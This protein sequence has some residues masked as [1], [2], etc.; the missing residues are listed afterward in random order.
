MRLTVLGGS[1]AGT[2]TGQGC[3]GY[4]IESATASI[5]LDL[6]PGTLQELRKHT[7]YRTLTAIVVSHLHVDHVADLLALRY[8]L[9]YNPVSPPGRM[10]LC[11]PPGGTAMLE[12]LAGVFVEPSEVAG[13]FGSV[14]DIAEYE[15][16]AGLTIGDLQLKFLPTVHFIPCWAIRITG[17]DAQSG[18]LTYT[19]D[20]G[21]AA[22][23]A[24]FAAG[25]RILVAEATYL[26]PPD[27]PREERGHLSA[28]EAG[29]V[30]STAGVAT[31]VL[32]HLWEELGFDRY[33][34]QAARRFTGRLE[35][36]R[37]GLHIEW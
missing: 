3:S 17:P 12:R 26:D 5:V 34:S 10:K 8:A 27:T 20:S 25:S 18:D 4:L 1:A 19:A 37:P 2:N 11:L 6:G 21:P 23:L 29:A 7:N 22:D 15:P 35:V 32:T 30:A 16:R 14:F 33:R 9:A 13:F 31:L 36:A 28:A 24:A